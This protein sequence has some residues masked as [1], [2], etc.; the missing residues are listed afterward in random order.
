VVAHGFEREFSGFIQSPVLPVNER[1]P[2]ID[3]KKF[4]RKDSALIFA[5]PIKKGA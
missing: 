2:I 4:G 5:I 1:N 3:E